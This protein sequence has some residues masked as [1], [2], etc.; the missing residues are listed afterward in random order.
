MFQLDKSATSLTR[1]QILD[2]AIGLAARYRKLSMAE[3]VM[4]KF[5][6]N[7]FGIE[8]VS[9]EG[10][11][12]RYV[13]TGETYDSTVY[14]ESREYFA[15]S[16]GAWL[17]SAESEHCE[18]TD[19]IRC[20]HCGEFTALCDKALS[21]PQGARHSWRETICEHCGHNVAGD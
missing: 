9:C 15:G 17:E 12:M 11:S 20:G 4:Q 8:S 21:E 13:N 2:L 19:T 6:I 1:E 16:W 14:C 7:T 10:R 18:A 5:G 3:Y